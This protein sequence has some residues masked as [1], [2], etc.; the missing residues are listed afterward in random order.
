MSAVDNLAMESAVERLVEQIFNANSAGKKLKICGGETKAALYPPVTSAEHEDVDLLPVN[1]TGIVS[2]QPSELVLTTRAGTK[3]SEIHTALAEQNQQLGFEPPSFGR[4]ATI[5]GTVAAALSG[6]ARPYMGSIR[7]AVLG[8]K[9]LTGDGHVVRFG[10]EVMKNVAGYDVSRLVVGSMGSIAVILEVSLRVTPIAGAECF[11]K[12]DCDEREAF[13]RMA[14]LNEQSLPITGLAFA[15]NALH[16]R[17]A[18][19]KIAVEQ[20]RGAMSDYADEGQ[21]FWQQLN[22]QELK[23]FNQPGNLWRL[24]LP[25]RSVSEM[26]ISGDRIWDWG[27]GLC[28][29]KSD[30]PPVEIADALQRAGGAA[31]LFK[32]EALTDERRATTAIGQIRERL[33]TVFDPHQLFVRRGQW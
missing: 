17:L 31:L 2:Y 30:A 13:R 5:G 23:F 27:G 16:L 26:E 25:F 14:E 21:V 32:G 4:N 15:D 12:I 33:R 24:T 9:L 20:T 28:W 3:L 19:S 1:Y 10:G 6:P 11:L 7:D 29:L 22:E 8:V 18:G